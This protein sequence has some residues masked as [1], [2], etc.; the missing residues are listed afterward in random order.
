[1][2]G[3]GD[4]PS[5]ILRLAW[6]VPLVPAHMIA[7]AVNIIEQQSQPLI[8]EYSRILLFINYLRRSW[9]RLANIV[10]VYGYPVRTNNVTEAFNRRAVMLLSGVHPELLAF[11]SKKFSYCQYSY[12]Q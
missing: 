10:S 9:V 6:A 11:L 12:P 2:R 5:D 7:L 4:V 8:E 1:M 3:Y